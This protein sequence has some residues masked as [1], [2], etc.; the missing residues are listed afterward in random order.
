MT[1]C[2]R[3]HYI[4]PKYN[5]IILIIIINRCDMIDKKV[6]FKWHVINIPLLCNLYAYMYTYADF[7]VNCMAFARSTFSS[8]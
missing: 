2:L 4:T 7:A 6:I 8:R 1:L 5:L 3:T